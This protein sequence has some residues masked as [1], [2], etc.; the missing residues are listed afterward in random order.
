MPHHLHYT[1]LVTNISSIQRGRGLYE[2]KYSRMQGSLGPSWG[3]P[4]H[5]LSPV[6]LWW[7]VALCELGKLKEGLIKP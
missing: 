5:P 3:L 1:I 7:R 4:T 6:P 2:G